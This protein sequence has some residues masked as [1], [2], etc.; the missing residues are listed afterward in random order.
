QRGVPPPWWEIHGAGD[1]RDG[2]V[3]L[4]TSL[5]AGSSCLDAWGPNALGQIDSWVAEPGHP[6]WRRLNWTITIPPADS[7]VMQANQEYVMAKIAISL[8]GTTGAGACDGC[9]EGAVITFDKIEITA[10]VP[11]N[12]QIQLPAYNN[13]VEWQNGPLPVKSRTWGGIKALYR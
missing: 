4:E 6:G 11:G 2:A 7:F 9:T 3:Q 10:E 5:A 13:T 12:I 8:A 1:C